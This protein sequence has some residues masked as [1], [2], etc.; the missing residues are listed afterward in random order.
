M[1]RVIHDKNVI[2][3]LRYLRLGHFRSDRG[4]VPIYKIVINTLRYLRL[5]HF[6]PYTLSTITPYSDQHLTVSEVRTHLTDIA[7]FDAD[8]K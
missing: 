6:N 2:N 7:N 1:V 8:N 4:V 3:T 5:G